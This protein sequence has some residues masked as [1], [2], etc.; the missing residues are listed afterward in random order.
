MNPNKLAIIAVLAVCQ[1]CAQIANIHQP[2][3][4]QLTATIDSADRAR[5]V[6]T[7]S[8]DS[9]D[10]QRIAFMSYVQCKS[11]GTFYET[12]NSPKAKPIN[13]IGPARAHYTTMMLDAEWI[14][15]AWSDAISNRQDFNKVLAIRF[16]ECARRNVKEN[17]AASMARLKSMARTAEDKKIFEM[18]SELQSRVSN[19]DGSLMTLNQAIASIKS[20]FTRADASYG[21]KG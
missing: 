11:V 6:S 3:I 14:A 13:F 16:S 7:Y 10:Y 17:L 12:L 18:L 5:L 1:G 19:I 2:P 21:M 4:E 15:K 8:Q 9:N 20:E